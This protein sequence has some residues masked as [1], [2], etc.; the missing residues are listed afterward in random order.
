MGVREGAKDTLA[1]TKNPFVYS[2]KNVA[3][4]EYR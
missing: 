1:A 2:I 4:Q 3:W